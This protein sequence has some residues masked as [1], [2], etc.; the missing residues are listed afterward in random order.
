ME[1]LFVAARMPF[2]YTYE[3]QILALCHPTAVLCT[4][5]HVHLQQISECIQS[6]RQRQEVVS[7]NQLCYRCHQEILVLGML[8][9]RK[10]PAKKNHIAIVIIIMI[11]CVYRAHNE[12]VHVKSVISFLFRFAFAT[13]SAIILY[14]AKCKRPRYRL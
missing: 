5:I 1:P 10:V 13:S 9:A 2:I 6:Y 7:L 11:G 4:R 14:E 3:H 8:C 12:N